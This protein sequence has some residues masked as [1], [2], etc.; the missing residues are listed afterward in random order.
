VGWEA[1]NGKY[2]LLGAQS[3]SKF[4]LQHSDDLKMLD[5]INDWGWLKG[6][7]KNVNV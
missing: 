7:F 3:G 4:G 6:E 5:K 1:R 2:C